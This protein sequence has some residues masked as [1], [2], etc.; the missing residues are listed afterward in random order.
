MAFKLEPLPYAR[1]A[2]TPYLSSET[3]ALHHGKHH[4][5]YVKKLNALVADRPE[6]N[7]DLEGLVRTAEGPVFDNAAQI[8]N[9]DFYWRSMKRG[10][11]GRPEEDLLAAIRAEFGSIEGFRDAFVGTGETRFGSGWVWLVWAGERLRVSSTADADCP[12]RRGEVALLT[13]DLWEHSYYL[14]YRN[15]RERY[16]RAFVDHLVSWDFAAAN[17]AAIA[18]SR[19]DEARRA[20][21][22]RG[23]DGNQGEGNRGADR[24][25][26]E[27]AT[28]FAR[29][30]RVSNAAR[31]AAAGLDAVGPAGRK[32]G[33]KL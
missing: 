14:D 10:G 18:S 20:K 32:P 5:G 33:Q 22:E 29:S 28:A 27:S 11:G 31:E 12:L 2:L 17:W 21:I 6:A 1:D 26:R 19:G 23:S 24:L 15:E 7:A 4:A 13:A 30:G 8:W 9:H 25:Y 3:L 16:L